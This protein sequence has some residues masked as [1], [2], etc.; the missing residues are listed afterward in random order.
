MKI[1]GDTAILD[2]EGRFGERTVYDTLRQCF[3]G[4]ERWLAIY[5]MAVLQLTD[6]G[7][8]PEDT[9]H[10]TELD[11]LVINRDFG[12]LLIEVKGGQ[13]RCRDHQWESGRNGNWR[14]LERS[15]MQQAIDGLFAIMHRANAAPAVGGH[16]KLLLHAPLVAFPLIERIHPLPADLNN[17]AMALRD[18]CS[19]PAKFE[20]WL[21]SN[22]FRLQSQH[23][24]RSR[25][26]A[27]RALLDELVM[28]T[29]TSEYGIRTMAGRMAAEDALPVVRPSRHDEFVR[30]RELRT[31]VLVHGP[32][33]S[34]KTIVGMIRAA[35]MLQSNP[36]AR[37]LILTYNRLVA[38]RTQST[39]AAAFGDRVV[40]D[41]YHEFAERAAKRAGIDL[42][43]PSDPT[44][45]DQYYRE[46]V[47]SALIQAT[48]TRA[49]DA[50]E[51]FDLLVID[52]AQDFNWRWI[53][54]LERMLKPT[55]VKWA[56]YD[57]QQF[58]FG[59]V[60]SEALSAQ[61]RIDEMKANLIHEFGEP[62]RLLRCYR[63]SRGIFRYLE[64]RG[65]L[66]VGVECDPLAYEG[67]TPTDETVPA[68]DVP[69]AV[70]SA[71]AHI[72]THLGIPPQQILVQTKYKPTNDRNPLCGHLGRFLDGRYQLAEYP[73]AN[74]EL[75]D[76]VPCVTISRYKGCERAATI[77][78]ESPEMKDSDGGNLL[79]TGLT[80][81]RLH[82][83]V[84]RVREG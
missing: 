16:V 36:S 34:G 14:S 26:Q 66:P 80:R 81:A 79:Y 7:P 30:E 39:M 41:S 55:A 35:R 61:D 19:D 8:L 18:T 76:A 25:T 46:D 38:A 70:K 57:P 63:M 75:P 78:V 54:S 83:H 12:L 5:G 47:P 17:D 82:L 53:V 22:F 65:M 27:V 64:S 71:A 28:P 40:V 37:A 24:I 68:R 32:A 44:L 45:L 56:L 58:I 6:K 29:V 10:L 62:D 21:G 15:P 4:D 13:I 84:V 67:A 1:Y 49:P 77:V 73:G 20:R 74:G 31:K 60:A 52:E 43:P 50:S 51:G 23:G 33:G 2:Q 72:I 9:K 59:S 42:S 48:A 69:E 3:E 11:F